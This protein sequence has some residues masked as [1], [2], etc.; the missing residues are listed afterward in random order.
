VVTGKSE[1]NVRW[2]HIVGCSSFSIYPQSCRPPKRNYRAS[3]L[4]DC[5]FGAQC[6]SIVL[7]WGREC[8]HLSKSTRCVVSWFCADRIDQQYIEHTTIKQMRHRA[9]NQESRIHLI[10]SD[11]VCIIKKNWNDMVKNIMCNCPAS[12]TRFCLSSLVNV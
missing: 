8:M 6:P 12:S 11:V 2:N 1:V 5:C 10:A 7:L 3:S 9:Q 4:W